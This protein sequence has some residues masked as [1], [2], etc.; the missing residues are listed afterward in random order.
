M[1][2]GEIFRNQKKN[3]KKHTW[4]TFQIY[5]TFH[6]SVK[7]DF[8]NTIYHNFQLLLFTITQLWKTIIKYPCYTMNRA[9]YVL[10]HSPENPG[11]ASASQKEISLGAGFWYLSFDGKGWLQPWPCCWASTTRSICLLRAAGEAARRS[12]NYLG[13]SASKKCHTQSSLKCLFCTQWRKT[14]HVLTST[15]RSPLWMGRSCRW[16]TLFLAFLCY[17]FK[18]KSYFFAVRET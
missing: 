11:W 6:R 4:P 10:H 3:K 12:T 13:G 7:K 17:L 5:K 15:S 8:F 9:V 18:Q 14:R 1:H 16:P 2:E